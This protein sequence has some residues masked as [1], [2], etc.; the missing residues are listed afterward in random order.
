MYRL[1]K[2]LYDLQQS[3][4]LWSEKLEKK[5]HRFSFIKLECCECAFVRKNEKF[6]AIILVYVDYLV[7][8][9][10]H[11]SGVK[12]S[13]PELASVFTIMDLGPS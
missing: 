13:R 5:L 7:I 8:P 9:S 2:R 12:W 3:P 1:R 11:L 4:R 6:E 10:S